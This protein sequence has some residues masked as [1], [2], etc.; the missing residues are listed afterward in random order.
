MHIFKENEVNGETFLLLFEDNFKDHV[1]RLGSRL[2]L[3][4]KQ[5]AIIER[6]RKSRAL[7]VIYASRNKS[8][9]PMYHTWQA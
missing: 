8:F 1:K 3:L 2:K 5:W 4:E 7:F 6:R 9:V